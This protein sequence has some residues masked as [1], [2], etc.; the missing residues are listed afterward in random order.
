MFL[1]YYFRKAAPSGQQK[2]Q[3]VGWLRQRV[4]QGA[5][6]TAPTVQQVEQ[7]ETTLTGRSRGFSEALPPGMPPWQDLL[8]S[9]YA[10]APAASTFRATIASGPGAGGGGIGGGRG[11]PAKKKPAQPAA[12]KPVAKKPSAWSEQYDENSQSVYYYNEETGESSWDKP[13]ELMYNEP[14]GARG[15]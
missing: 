8:D 6:Q 3:F 15:W 14:A 13:P 7:M 4:Y 5:V 2:H 9:Y 12:P 1:E 10:N 11:P